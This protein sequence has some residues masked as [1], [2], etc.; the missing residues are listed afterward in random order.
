MVE[1]ARRGT[2]Q[3][4]VFY[5]V[6][7][8]AVAEPPHSYSTRLPRQ[9]YPRNGVVTLPDRRPDWPITGPDQ[10]G[11]EPGCYGRTSDEQGKAQK[12]SV[13]ARVEV[14]ECRPGI[15]QCREGGGEGRCAGGSRDAAGCGAGA[16][17]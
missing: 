12:D 1:V 3:G 16:L 4:T 11:A 5:R 15:G 7:Y 13:V 8:D 17:A 14:T 10:G 9:L 2:S 6:G